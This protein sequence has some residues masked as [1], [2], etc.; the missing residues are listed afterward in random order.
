MEGTE[1]TLDPTDSEK[2]SLMWSLLIAHVYI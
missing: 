1:W 2:I